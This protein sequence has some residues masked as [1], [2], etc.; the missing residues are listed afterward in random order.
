[1]P[2]VVAVGGEENQNWI[3]S[4]HIDPLETA[5]CVIINYTV[6]MIV[7]CTVKYGRSCAAS[8]EV[9]VLEAAGLNKSMLLELLLE[10]S[11][12]IYLVH[13]NNTLIS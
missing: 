5:V 9:F 3:F 4:S 10:P 11:M 1:M 13:R 12:A 7:N 6:Y 8:A 2:S